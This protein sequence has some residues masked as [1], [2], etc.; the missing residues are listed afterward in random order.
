MKKIK[1]IKDHQFKATF[2]PP[3]KGVERITQVHNS[4][5]NAKM[6]KN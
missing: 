6:V 2:F 5:T 1:R 4:P 3:V